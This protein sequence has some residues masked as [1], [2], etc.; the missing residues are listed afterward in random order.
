MPMKETRVV[1]TE[2]ARRLDE[3][4]RQLEQVAL[5]CRALQELC[6][7]KKLI[8][9][10][11]VSMLMNE[12]DAVDGNVDGANTRVARVPRRGE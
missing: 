7:R 3:L 4:Q 10:A 1:D 8:T 6:I 2:V 9:R 11:E 12:I 5:Q